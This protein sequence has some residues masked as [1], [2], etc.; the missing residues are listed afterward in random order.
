[1]INKC[2]EHQTRE[3]KFWC[4]FWNESPRGSYLGSNEPSFNNGQMHRKHWSITQNS[5]LWRL[6]CN[7]RKETEYN[8]WNDSTEN[9]ACSISCIQKTQGWDIESRNHVLNVNMNIW[10]KTQFVSIL[11]EFKISFSMCFNINTTLN[12]FYFHFPNWQIKQAC[13]F[14]VRILKYCRFLL[15]H[16]VRRKE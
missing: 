14:H 12:I 8:V 2:D 11:I 16:S 6:I 15:L 9:L 3:S 1:M 4:V 13:A 10:N 7:I 5:Q